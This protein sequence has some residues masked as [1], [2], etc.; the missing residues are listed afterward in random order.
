MKEFPMKA[1]DLVIEKANKRP[2]VLVNIIESNVFGGDAIVTVLWAGQSR[3][4]KTMMSS[5]QKVNP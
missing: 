5:L 4:L 1:G 2:G 3:V